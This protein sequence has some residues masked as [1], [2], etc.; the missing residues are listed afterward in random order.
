M[1][2]RNRKE[3]CNGYILIPTNIFREKSVRQKLALSPIIPKDYFIRY[4]PMYCLQDKPSGTLL[5]FE[6]L[7][8]EGKQCAKRCY[9]KQDGGQHT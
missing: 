1:R 6:S 8:E 2:K 9:G 5:P 3:A 7:F 4:A